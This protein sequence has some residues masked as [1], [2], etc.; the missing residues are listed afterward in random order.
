MGDSNS[1]KTPSSML[2]PGAFM[3]GLRLLA[4]F[5][6]KTLISEIFNYELG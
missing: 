6:K 5:K 2:D 3:G 1:E 4:D